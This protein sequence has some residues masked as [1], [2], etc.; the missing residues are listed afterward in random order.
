MTWYNSSE[1]VLILKINSLR[2][3]NVMVILLI[4]KFTYTHPT[5]VI[6]PC[7]LKVGLRWVQSLKQKFLEKLAR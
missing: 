3:R 2:T 6:N 4:T 7:A 5:E 1:N